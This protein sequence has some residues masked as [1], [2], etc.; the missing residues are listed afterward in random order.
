MRES[1]LTLLVLVKTFEMIFL[2]ILWAFLATTGVQ[3]IMILPDTEAYIGVC[4]GIC[5]LLAMFQ[6]LY[7]TMLFN[8][9]YRCKMNCFTLGKCV[10]DC[11]NFVFLCTCCL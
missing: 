3:L 2:F 10:F 7:N 4:V 6:T 11:F 1:T 5:L 8:C 9:R